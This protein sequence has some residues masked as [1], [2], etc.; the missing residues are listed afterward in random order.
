MSPTSP[1]ESALSPPVN[2][3]REVHHEAVA[4]GPWFHN[5]HLPDG[6]QTR[7]S[8]DQT[9]GDFP[10]W[11]WGEIADH[12]PSD[13]RGQ[14]VLDIGCNAGFYS[15]ALAQRGAEVLGIDHDEH[16]LR[17]ARWA[18]S[19]IDPG[20]GSVRFER[21]DIYD[22]LRSSQT[23]DL[24]LFMGV[25]Y[26]LRYPLLGL[27]TACDRLKPGGTLLFQSL[28][29]P[30]GLPE[31]GLTCS[32]GLNE[33]EPLLLPEYPKLA[34]F[35]NG[36]A[37]DPTNCFAPNAA[38]VEAMLRSNGLQQ[39]TRL[40]EETWIARR[41]AVNADAADVDAKG[42]VDSVGGGE[43]SGRPWWRGKVFDRFRGGDEPW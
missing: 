1:P 30:G 3:E 40:A 19:Q 18:Q 43:P 20:P 10:A 27:D 33:R 15:F 2:I 21:G 16:Y 31:P 7:S 41:P 13:L 8:L 14:R 6:T 35:E 24:I 39:L 38:A 29:M 23:F 25:F 12:L 37:G 36:W 5:L 42:A 11:K 4:L 28:T 34:Y 22:L 17:Q 26:H 32:R 9:L